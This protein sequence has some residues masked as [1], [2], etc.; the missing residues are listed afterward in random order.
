MIRFADNQNGYRE[1][2]QKVPI[3]VEMNELK[4]WF[5]R[6]KKDRQKWEDTKMITPQKSSQKTNREPNLNLLGCSQFD[7]N[8][9]RE[10]TIKL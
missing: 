10:G 1:F 6:R 9:F 8:L 7:L 2:I 3:P 5:K 4:V